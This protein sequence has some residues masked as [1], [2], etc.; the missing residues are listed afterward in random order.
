MF[1]GKLHEIAVVL[2][3]SMKF[4]NYRSWISSLLLLRREGCKFPRETFPWAHTNLKIKPV[5][6]V[7]ISEPCLPEQSPGPSRFPSLSPLS[8]VCQPV[9]CPGSLW[10]FRRASLLCKE[11]SFSP[12]ALQVESLRHR[13][14]KSVAEG[15]Q[16][17]PLEGFGAVAL[18]WFYLVVRSLFLVRK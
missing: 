8:S 4:Q 9:P 3:C 15:Y 16:F 17:Q 5:P 12:S 18:R 14:V 13:D 6:D 1:W 2:C 7:F 11:W 10:P